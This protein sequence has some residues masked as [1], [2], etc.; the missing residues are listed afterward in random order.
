MEELGLTARIYEG[1]GIIFITP[2]NKI[3]IIREGK[4]NKWGVCKGRRKPE[5]SSAKLSTPWSPKGR[6][7]DADYLATAKREA[8]EELG[9]KE[10][11]YDLD[12][13]PFIFPRSPYT[14]IFMIAKL[15]VDIHA[16]FA[17]KSKDFVEEDYHEISEIKTITLKELCDEFEKYNYN[18]YLRLLRACILMSRLLKRKPYL[19]GVENIY[20][21]YILNDVRTIEFYER[22]R[23]RFY[24]SALGYYPDADVVLAPKDFQ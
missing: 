8:F 7:E 12:N 9:L 4:S 2:D 10:D 23:P 22:P 1:A 3:V 15:K 21:S 17:S 6:H 20:R 13:D 18:I 14:Y 24:N 19:E 16:T 11:D 5:D